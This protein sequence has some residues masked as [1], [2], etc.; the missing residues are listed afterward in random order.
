MGI[1]FISI[2]CDNLFPTTCRVA[3][4]IAAKERRH[5]NC[6]HSHDDR[7]NSLRVGQFCH[8]QLDFYSKISTLPIFIS[9]TIFGMFFLHNVLDMILQTTFCWMVSRPVPSPTWIS[10]SQHCLRLL[11]THTRDLPLC[12]ECSA[13][14][15]WW[16][17]II[18]VPRLHAS[19]SRLLVRPELAKLNDEL[20]TRDNFSTTK[21]VKNRV[22]T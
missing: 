2:S 4:M 19:H 12:S 3:M 8:C 20:T 17:W 22:F 18:H 13:I 15:L 7:L 10:Q 14:A 6:D 5:D 16:G 9:N 21:K 11:P 1:L